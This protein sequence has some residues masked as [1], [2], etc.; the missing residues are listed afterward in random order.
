MR[1]APLFLL[2]PFVGA[3]FAAHAAQ[4]ADSCLA[5]CSAAKMSED[6]R[7]TCRLGCNQ[8]SAPP[9]ATP[10]PPP[11]QPTAR[12]QPTPPPTPSQPPPTSV[13]PAPPAQ[14]A[15]TSTAS[16]ETS[17]NSEPVDDRSTCRLMCA[18]QNR[19]AT[20]LPTNGG[21]QPSAQQSYYPPAPTYAAQP[22]PTYNYPPQPQPTPTYAYPPTQPQPQYNYPPQPQP[23]PQPTPTYAYP[24]TQPQPTPTYAY[25]PSQPPQ[26]TYSY[27]PTQPTT[28]K[29]PQEIATCQSACKDGTSTDRATCRLNCAAQSTVVTPASSYNV[30]WGA[31]P[32][33]DAAARAAVIRQSNN[34]A[35]PVNPTYPT[36]PQPQPQPQPQPTATPQP[37]PPPPVAPPPAYNPARVQQ[38]A[39]AAQ[40]C[41]TACAETI[42]PCS[43]SCDQGRMS[44]TDRATCKLTCDGNADVCSDDCRAREKTCNAAR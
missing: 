11:P 35:G 28:S 33:N 20:Q 25:P 16:C 8:Q 34:V 2:A 13:Y 42:V 18:Q 37:A 44:S 19:P 14:P 41:I 21:F 15:P 6:D 12:P 29:S 4:P 10:T 31:P 5:S 32:P 39:A 26:P 24:P 9:A 3:A 27:P 7:A 17:C 1:L 30:V 43:H 40:S 36:Y 23:Q 22:Q 38:C